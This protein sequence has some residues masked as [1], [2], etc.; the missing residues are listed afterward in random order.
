MIKIYRLKP[1]L[2]YTAFLS[3]HSGIADEVGQIKEI[4]TGH[5]KDFSIIKKN[6]LPNRYLTSHAR[7]QEMTV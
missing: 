6:F 4:V 1:L 5:G 7:V 3:P 2:L